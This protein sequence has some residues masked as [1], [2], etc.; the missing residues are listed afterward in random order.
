MNE[1]SLF[2][3]NPQYNFRVE[4]GDAEKEKKVFISL[5]QKHRRALRDDGETDLIIGL[6]IYK[7]EDDFKVS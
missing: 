6:S 3:T 1:L 4:S 5:M 7:R 2:A